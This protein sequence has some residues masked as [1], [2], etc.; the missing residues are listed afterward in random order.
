MRIVVP[1]SVK[2]YSE[3]CCTVKFRKSKKNIA[4]MES[5]YQSDYEEPLRELQRETERR[6]GSETQ[7]L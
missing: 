6:F 5:D 7:Y 1:N 4:K 2:K 3:K